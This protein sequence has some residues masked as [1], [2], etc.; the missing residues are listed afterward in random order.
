MTT[1]QHA[2]SAVRCAPTVSR[3]ATPP[4]RRRG[5]DIRMLLSPA[6]V[7]STSGFLGT[8]TLEP[9]EVVTEHWHPYSEEFLY[10][11]GGVVT[12]A[13]RRRGARAARRVGVSSRSGC[14]TGWSTTRRRTGLPRVPPAPAGAPARPRP[15]RHRGCPAGG[16]MGCPVSARR[17]R[18]VITGVGVV[19]PGGDRARGLLGPA[20][21][22]PDGDP[23]DLASSTRAG[24]ARRSPPSATSTRSAAGLTAAGVHRNDR[25]VAVRP[26]RG[27][28]AVADSGLDLRSGGATPLDPDR[29]GVS[30]AARS[31]PRCGW[32]TSTSSSATAAGTGWSTRATP[33]RS[34]YHALV[35]SCLA[36]EV[37]VP[38]RRRT[39][40]P[41]WSP[42]AAPPGIDAVGYGSQLI[43]DGEADVVIA[44]ASDAP[45]SPIT[46][47][48][49]DAIR[50]TTAR[51]DDPEHAS[52]PF[53]ATRD[54]FVLG[55]G[56]AVLVLE[57]LEHARRRGAHIYCEIAGYATRCNAFHM[58]GL[59]PDGVE[60]AEAIRVALDA[61]P[62]RPDAVD[63]VNAH[64]SGT[65]QNDRHE[66]AA[67]KRSLGAHAYEV[68]VSSIKSMVGPLARR[69]R[70]D[71]DRRLRAG[72][73]ARR[74]AADRQ[75]R[76]RPTR[77]ATSTTCR[78]TAREH[79][80]RRRAVGGQRVRR[81]PVARSCWPARAAE[82]ASE[83][84]A[85]RSRG[86]RPRRRRPQRRRR[87][88]ALGVDPG[89]ASA[90]S[91][92]RPASTPA[93]YA[94]TL[95][96]QVRDFDAEDHV[97]SRL[98]RADRPV[99]LDR[100]WPRPTG[101]GRRRLRPGRSTTPYDDVGGRWR[102][103]PAAT[104]SAS[105]RSSGCG[106]RGRQSRQRLPVD[107]LVL[108]G[109]H[110]PDLHPA[111]ASRARRASWSARRRAGWTASPR[112]AGLVRRGTPA[113]LAGGTEAP[114]IAP[115]RWPASSTSGRA[116]ARRDPRRRLPAL[117]RAGRRLRAGR[118]RRDAARRGRR[119]RAGRAARQ[120]VY[121]EI[122]GYAATHDAA[123][124]R[125][126]AAATPPV[127]SRHAPRAGRRGRRR[128]TR[129]TW[130]SPTAPASPE[131][132]A[133]EAAA[134]RDGVRRRPPGA[135]HRAAG[136]GRPAVR[137]AARR[138]TWRPRCWR[139]A[140]GSCPAAGN[141]DDP[142]RGTWRST[143]SADRVQ[144]SSTV[145]VNARGFGGFNSSLVLRR[146]P[147]GD[148]MTM[149]GGDRPTP[150]PR[151]PYG[152]CCGCACARGP[153][154]QF[155]DAWQAAA[156][157]ISRVPGNLRQELP[158]RRRP[159]RAPS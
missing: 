55:E 97:P 136:P 145:V 128:R 77:S 54:G 89:A 87:R 125:G 122:A 66:T 68:P 18:V 22:R 35:P 31:A 79:A 37:A 32:R 110:R 116:A 137:R 60:M 107:R 3:E 135:G 92:D 129:S 76:A 38:V 46:M 29:V 64:G 56:A 156:A 132:D 52:R 6:T 127:R 75:L 100:R 42:P 65:K 139:C 119:R 62:A 113:V 19:A 91:A 93:Q 94:A 88:G 1:I 121:G 47:A 16:S 36:T 146:V 134:I 40:R 11:A 25:F 9:G 50:A 73:R 26:G 148:A 108:R 5:G 155:E 23:P 151:A 143:S 41:R 131:L 84:G 123:P 61:G 115:T 141:L 70:L 7:G 39:A 157:Q 130:C 53:D 153:R 21:R 80:G 10:C 45:I 13:A 43:A 74:R 140:T 103:G 126:P 138:W 120:Q 144:A 133:L 86:H 83:H 142:V 124:P 105:G 34:C 59:R 96:G 28:E 117:R 95:A 72:D 99:D 71:R 51:N 106:A 12:A 101:A 15:R 112:R 58:T 2:P 17:R 152:P 104:S 114:L 27:G 98:L 69:H 49:F 111:R 14:A 158:A 150:P 81:V 90:A 48:C 4:N 20:D 63:Y 85:E 67:F 147:G 33:L 8:L 44:G 159:T 24:S 30:W 154:S 149:T 57:E 78:C 102:P 118:G 82:A 109:H